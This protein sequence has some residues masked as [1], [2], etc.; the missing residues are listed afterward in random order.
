MLWACI[1][2][3][4]LITLLYV[5]KTQLGSNHI[6]LTILSPSSSENQAQLDDAIF[7]AKDPTGPGLGN[8]NLVPRVPRETGMRLGESPC[9]CTTVMHRER[10]H[11]YYNRALIPSFLEVRRLNCFIL[12]MNF[13]LDFVWNRC[14]DAPLKLN[15]SASGHAISISTLIVDRVSI[16]NR[17]KT[18]IN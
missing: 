14:I 8:P 10:R 4:I 6:F 11:L 2:S 7:R 12:C 18:S 1:I 15:K 3:F 9:T 17:W 16:E 13:L 5:C